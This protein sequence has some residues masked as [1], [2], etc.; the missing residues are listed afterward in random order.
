MSFSQ[1]GRIS[2][3]ILIVDL[4]FAAYTEVVFFKPVIPVHNYDGFVK[5]ILRLESGC[6]DR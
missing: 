1:M 4:H 6:T 3:F 5:S 2:A